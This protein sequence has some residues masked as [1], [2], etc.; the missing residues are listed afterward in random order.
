MHAIATA[1]PA[2][3]SLLKP[4]APAEID[5]ILQRALEKDRD[6]RYANA[7]EFADALDQ[8][9][10]PSSAPTQTKR[11]H[12]PFAG[13]A[14]ELNRLRNAWTLTRQGS[15]RT[16]IICGEP[17]IGKSALL[18][19]FLE[20]AT[21][22]DEF[23]VGRGA[24]VEQHGAGEAYLPF[25]Q[26]LQQLLSGRCQDYVLALFRRFV[27]TWC[28]QF[29]ALFSNTTV[30]QFQREAIGSTR[31]RMLRE[32]G[33]VL[34]ELTGTMPV[35]LALEDLHWAD[36]ATIDLLRYLGQKAVSH[37]FLLLGTERP[38]GNAKDY[39]LLRNLKRELMAQS[40]CEEIRLDSLP[41]EDI[42]SYLKEHFAPN[43][44]PPELAMLIYRRT[45]GHP[46]FVTGVLHLL[47]ERGDVVRQDGEWVLAKP[48]REVEIGVPNSVRGM[49]D[50]RLD[51]LSEEDR[52]M[53]QYASVQGVDFLSTVLGDALPGNDL[54]LEES[55]DRVQTAHRLIQRSGEEDLPAGDVA[56]RYRFAHALYRDTLHE[57]LLPK[58]RIALHQRAGE[59]LERLYSNQRTRVAIALSVHFERAHSY[60]KAIDYLEMAGE[61]AKAIFVHSQAIEFYDHALDLAEKIAEKERTPCRIRLRK[62]RGDAWLT[63]G[64]PLDAEKDYRAAL[65]LAEGAGDL[66]ASCRALIDLANV[67]MYTRQVHE[68]EASA[69]CQERRKKIPVWRCKSEPLGVWL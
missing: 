28:I 20:E 46:L 64:S 62:R 67:H 56:I 18:C 57:M 5:A 19:R 40:A 68:I 34:T 38:E 53:L 25:L 15:G 7:G 49:I 22:T 48:A 30:D 17:G 24:C 23:L 4:G 11:P 13:R 9:L 31:E 26:A 45:E 47:A 27:P 35:V 36:S 12:A 37:R 33:D 39:R 61:N 63:L 43:R 50:K 14:S 69:P 59:S 55:L 6:L 8:V 32:L 10:R 54:T 21:A 65:S 44:F 29:S 1:K 3:P 42:G 51:S 2:E 41:E 52:P 16:I 66:P 60:E 58:R